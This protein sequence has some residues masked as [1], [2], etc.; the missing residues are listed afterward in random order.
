MRNPVVDEQSMMPCRQVT[1]WVSSHQ[2]IGQNRT[3]SM[4]R[5]SVPTTSK[6]SILEQVKEELTKK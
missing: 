2:C 3:S 4:Q 5:K 1:G 6:V